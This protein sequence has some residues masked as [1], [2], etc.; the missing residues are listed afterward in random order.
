MGGTGGECPSRSVSACVSVVS[1]V[2]TPCSGAAVGVVVHI[3]GGEAGGREEADAPA[4]A[5]APL[6]I[7]RR[8]QPACGPLHL[9]AVSPGQ[10][11]T[12]ALS[13]MMLP[14]TFEA[15]GF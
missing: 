2:C 6:A 10:R 9:P 5:A 12:H 7:T 3:S 11:L 8:R 15:S 14:S 4:A 13:L 1:N